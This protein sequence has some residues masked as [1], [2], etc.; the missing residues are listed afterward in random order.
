[1]PQQLQAPLLLLLLPLLLLLL[2]AEVA[3]QP[4]ALPAGSSRGSQAYTDTPKSARR[5]VE[6]SKEGRAKGALTQCAP[7]A[8]PEPDPAA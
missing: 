3:W 7:M 8:E 6:Q 5:E 2:P 4:A 1:M